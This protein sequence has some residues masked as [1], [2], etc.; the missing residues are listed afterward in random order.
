MSEPV[1][2]TSQ[3]VRE[4]RTGGKP[5]RALN[6]VSLS[7]ET[8]E[9]LSVV[10]RSG[11]GKSTLMNI[12]GGLDRPTSGTV[13]VAGQELAKLSS[14]GLARYRAN[15]VGFVFQSFNLMPRYRAWENVALPL[16]F[17]GLD[18]TTR[19]KRAEALLE[20]VGLAG[21]SDHTP[22]EMSGGEQQRVAVARALVGKP[23][24]LLCDE[25]TGNLD[26]TNADL[27]MDL[28]SEV[29]R[30]EGTTVLLVTHDE[31][32]ARSRSERV[33]RMSDGQVVSDESA[34]LA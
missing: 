25:P 30:D 5:L 16:V 8:G 33:I 28:L 10:G 17:M 15:V 6:G 13:R 3:L 22:A 29:H 21:R 14:R 31:E 7:I 2:L 23:R 32:L 19:R 12:L 11:S 1:I 24:V 20:R 34:A 18:E 9:M 4:Y 27:I 26:S